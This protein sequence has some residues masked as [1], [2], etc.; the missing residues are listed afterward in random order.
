MNKP[1]YHFDIIA[2]MLLY[3]SP[4]L[5]VCCNIF[6]F[7]DVVIF[8]LMVHEFLFNFWYLFISLMQPYNWVSNTSYAFLFSPFSQAVETEK[9]RSELTK[10]RAEL[11]PWEKQ[12]IEHKGKLEVRCT[13]QKLLNEKVT[14]LYW[15]ISLFPIVSKTMNWWWYYCSKYGQS[16]FFCRL[17]FSISHVTKNLSYLSSCINV[18]IKICC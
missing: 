2:K 3:F 1:F 4:I 11:E 18:S 14:L 7:L 16:R 8:G 15:H 12:L 13:E 9:Y 6:L 17:Y 5:H 10:V